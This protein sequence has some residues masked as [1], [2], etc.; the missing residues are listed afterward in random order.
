MMSIMTMLRLG[1]HGDLSEILG[2]FDEAVAWLSGL[3]RQ[4]QWGSVP[5]SAVP[6]RVQGVRSTLDSGALWIAE[7]DGEVAG[8]LVLGEQP[9]SYVP[10]VAEPELYVRLLLTSRRLRGRGI[11]T[12][13]LEHARGQATRRRIG[14]LRVDCWAGGDGR[15]VRYYVEAGFSP[16]ERFDRDGWPGQV[17]EQRLV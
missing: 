5:W 6:E 1:Y 11:G 16:T 13:L 17:L 14:L 7:V 9:P 15:L 3:G 4:D 8:A 12:A 2:M 10:A